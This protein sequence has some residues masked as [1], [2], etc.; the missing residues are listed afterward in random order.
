M[1]KSGCGVGYPQIFGGFLIEGLGLSD[2]TTMTGA[3][4]LTHHHSKDLEVALFHP[5]AGAVNLYSTKRFAN[6]KQRDLARATW[7][8][9]PMPDCR[10][11][12]DN[13]EV[14]H[15]TPWASGGPHRNH[16]GRIRMRGGT[17]V[18][19]SPRGTPVP[20][21]THQFGAMHLLFGK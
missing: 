21:T 1:D 6:T 7:T 8:T 3:E 4:Y 18:W 5:Q 13:C 15:I 19:V 10:H 14:H 2:G 11:A 12:A 9:C 16:R 17:P 20:H